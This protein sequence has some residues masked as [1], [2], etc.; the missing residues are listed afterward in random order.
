MLES[1]PRRGPDHE[2]IEVQ[3]GTDYRHPEGAGG[4]CEDG[5]SV[6]LARDQKRDVLSLEGQIRRDGRVGREAAEDA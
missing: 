2:E 1:G 3:R 5:G 4:R 6:P